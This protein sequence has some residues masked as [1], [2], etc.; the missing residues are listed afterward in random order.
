MST[1]A[2]FAGFFLII[3]VLWEA[4]ETVIFPRRVARRCE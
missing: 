4:F 3:V 2:S 1:V